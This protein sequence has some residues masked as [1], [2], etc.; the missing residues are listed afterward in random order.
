MAMLRL[1]KLP[2]TGQCLTVPTSIETANVIG[3]KVQEV[4]HGLVSTL[5]VVIERDGSEQVVVPA[6]HDPFVTV[7]I[8]EEIQY[9]LRLIRA[10]WIDISE[11][12][13]FDHMLPFIVRKEDILGIKFNAA[14]GGEENLDKQRATFYLK[15]E[16]SD[17][18]VRSSPL[19][20]DGLA[21][22]RIIFC[23]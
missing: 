13:G 19:S 1:D 6:A 7:Q 12:P 3:V 16:G 22:F 10:E 14:G 8:L 4:K 21:M 11:L 17:E 9:F 23:S 18:A 15:L 2:I 20:V 5:H